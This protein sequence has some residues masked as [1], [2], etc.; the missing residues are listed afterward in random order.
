[1]WPSFSYPSPGSFFLLSRGWNTWQNVDGFTRTFR[2]HLQ[3]THLEEYERVVRTLRLKHYEE[4]EDSTE[5]A[6][7]T[8]D[9]PFHV[10]EWVRR[11]IKWVVVDDQV[12][13]VSSFSVRFLTP[14]QAINV[15]DC[16]EFRDFALYGRDDVRDSDLP[17]RT[18]LTELV[19]KTYETEHLKLK[20]DLDVCVLWITSHSLLTLAHRNHWD[21]SHSHRIVGVT[22]T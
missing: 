7:S 6:V 21:V 19:F 9:G 10:D 16:K 5:A 3:H 22:R 2:L 13:S 15:V 17:H 12:R 8:S 14:Y 11:L 20:S 4:L 18:K 1:M